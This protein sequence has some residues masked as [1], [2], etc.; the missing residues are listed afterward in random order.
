[1]KKLLILIV[2]CFSVN[3]FGQSVGDQYCDDLGTVFTISHVSNT[4][5]NIL[6]TIEDDYGF[7]IQ[8]NE[9]GLQSMV[10]M[11]YKAQI[12]Y[13]N[14]CKDLILYDKDL[15]I[16]RTIMLVGFAVGIV[17]AVFEQPKQVLIGSTIL[18]TGAIWCSF[19]FPIK[20]KTKRK[21]NLNN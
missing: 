16:G 5:D 2:L 6:F 18:S 14:I 17:G 3:V 4:S 8:T 15:R 13:D 19:C 9:T 10:Y 21:F 7:K 1:M 11:P 20:T 12:P